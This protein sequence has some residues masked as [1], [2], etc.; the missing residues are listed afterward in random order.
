MA[1]RKL[2]PMTIATRPQWRKLRKL[3]AAITDGITPE[4][5]AALAGIPF[6]SIQ[7][8]R[9]AEAIFRAQAVHQRNSLAI[10]E[11]AARDS[12]K[13]EYG[14]SPTQ[15]NTEAAALAGPDGRAPVRMRAMAQ[16]G[17][18]KAVAWKLERLYA[19][20]YGQQQPQQVASAVVDVLHALA[21]LRDQPATLA[22]H[23]PRALADGKQE[24]ARAREGS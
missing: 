4:R 7:Q 22:V 3:L 12:I 6:D 21:A 8:P 10:I 2:S 11:A 15:S 9:M 23:Q 5:A 18:W 1:E 13:Y 20:E 19:S 17:D 14:W 16:R 24:H